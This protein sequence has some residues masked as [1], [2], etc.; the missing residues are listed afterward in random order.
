MVCVHPASLSSDSASVAV[1][2]TK[3]RFR[4]GFRARPLHGHAWIEGDAVS[5]HKRVAKHVMEVCDSSVTFAN[6]RE[7]ID[8]SACTRTCAV[9]IAIV[10]KHSMRFHETSRNTSCAFAC[11]RIQAHL[12]CFSPHPA[13]RTSMPPS[14]SAMA[15]PDRSSHTHSMCLQWSCAVP[16]PC[17]DPKIMQH[18]LDD[19]YVLVLSGGCNASAAAPITWPHGGIRLQ[20]K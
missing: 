16:M 4:Q 11:A 3:N 9:P 20:R 7:W 18:T 5:D 6:G 15:A 10:A 13:R 14:G 17:L 1:R 12:A 19:S 8:R 2:K